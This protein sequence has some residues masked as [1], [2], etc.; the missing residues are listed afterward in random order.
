[1]NKSNLFSSKNILLPFESM[2]CNDRLSNERKQKDRLSNERKQKDQQQELR[3]LHD[4]KHHPEQKQLQQEQQLEQEKQ[5]TFSSS[6]TKR[7]CRINMIPHS[8]MSSPSGSTTSQTAGKDKLHMIKPSI[9]SPP[10]KKPKLYYEM[11]EDDDESDDKKMIAN[12]TNTTTRISL[13]SNTDQ[14]MLSMFL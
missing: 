5:H 11:A 14:G 9:N 10:K 6:S 2:N 8:S 4:Q 1:M 13:L 12:E 3:E 7:S